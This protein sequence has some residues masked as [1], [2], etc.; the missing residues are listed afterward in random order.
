MAGLISQ[1]AVNAFDNIR[2][3]IFNVNNI[4]L[5]NRLDPLSKSENFINE[6]SLII[7]G[8]R[9]LLSMSAGKDSVFLFTLI[10]K[11]FKKFRLTVAVFHL[12]HLQRGD[13]SD[14]EQIFV[15]NLSASAGWQCFS[16]KASFDTAENKKSFEEQARDA[17]YSRLQMIAEQHGFNRI[18]T[19]HTLD[20]NVETILMRIFSGT[21]LHG[22]KGIPAARGMIVRPMLPLRSEEIYSYLRDKEISWMEDSSNM[23]TVYSRNYLRNNV[24]P[25]ISK[26]FPD[27][28]RAV[29]ILSGIAGDASDIIDRHIQKAY[30]GT[31]KNSGRSSLIFYK[32][33]SADKPVLNHLLADSVRKAGGLP[34]AAVISEIYRRMESS[35]SSYTDLYQNHLI[36]IRKIL[37]KG[38]P[39]I[40]IS[41]VDNISNHSFVE[42]KINNTDNDLINEIVTGGYTIRYSFLC[43]DDCR[44]DNADRIYIFLE[45]NDNSN[46]KI[47][48]RL[49]GDRIKLSFGTKKIKDIMIDVKLDPALKER[50]PLLDINGRVA[51]YMP[52][53][54]NLGK[55]IVSSENSADK[56]SKKV[57]AIWSH[58]NLINP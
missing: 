33:I 58:K 17:R 44:M 32:N 24:I 27:M 9:L 14:R 21:G 57:L 30:P 55:N 50:V 29:A 47:R 18:V 12:N 39:C 43:A 11:I 6:N 8:D 54:L 36:I 56:R 40:E 15:E 13:E 1:P 4:L 45:D 51:A 25:V 5:E 23:D 22:L 46:I 53:L 20:D 31:V 16:E 37:M 28:H 38:E 52:G 35:N 7:H 19:A 26:R 41:P 2:P 42:F 3:A 34:S 10:R 48:N 49:P